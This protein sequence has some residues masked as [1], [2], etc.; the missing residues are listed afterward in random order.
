MS[1]RRRLA[2]HRAVLAAMLAHGPREADP[3]GWPTT[4]RPP[5]TAR[6]CCAWAP[7]AAGRAAAAG[8]HREATAQYARALRHADA[9]A[10]GPRADLLQRQADECFTT[11]Q[12][13]AAIAAQREALA[14]A[15]TPATGSARATPCGRCRGCPL[16]NR[17]EEGEARALEAVALLEGLPAG[18][19]L[20]MAYANLSQR[21]MVVEEPEAVQRGMGRSSSPSAS[22][23][24]TPRPTRSPTS[25]APSCRPTRA[26]APRLEQVLALAPEH[27]LE[28]FAGRAF[29]ALV[30]CRLRLR[31]FDLAVR[32][33]DAGLRRTAPSAAWRPGGCTSSPSPLLGRSLIQF[34]TLTCCQDRASSSIF[35]HSSGAELQFFRRAMFSS[36]CASDDVPG[37]VT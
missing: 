28:E 22:A 18:R 3:H 23:T 17:T 2:L 21:R 13:D 29:S 34:N 4:P 36:R 19:E 12:F 11:A 24:T 37:S 14:G 25:V 32:P 6:R 27:G 16:R 9:L 30:M 26:R 8:A 7:R 20:A 15:A 5:A 1:P 31:R 35:F 10:P 33:L